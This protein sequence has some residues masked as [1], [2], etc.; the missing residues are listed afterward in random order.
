MRTRGAGGGGG[1][2]EIGSEVV[3]REWWCGDEGDE[4]VTVL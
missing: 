3:G 1:G 2:G 4:G